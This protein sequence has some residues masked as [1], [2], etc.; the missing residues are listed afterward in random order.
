MKI[1]CIVGGTSGI[2]KAIAYQ[3]AR[4]DHSLDI[5][6]SGRNIEEGNK[7]V[8][9]LKVLS[10]KRNHQFRQIDAFLLSNIKNYCNNLKDDIKREKSSLKYLVLT[11]GI[12]SIN[13]RT[14]TPEGI[15]QKLALHYYGRMLFINELLPVLNNQEHDDDVRVVSVLSGSV[16]SPYNQMK[17]DP[18][19]KSNFSIVN[20]ANAAGFYNDLMLDSF[21]QRN[22]NISFIHAAPGFVATN[23][24]SEFPYVLKV[25]VRGLQVF[26][27]SLE[28]CGVNMA[29]ALYDDKFRPKKDAP[30][31]HVMKQDGSIGSVTSGHSTENITFISQH[32]IDMFNNKTR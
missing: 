10:P 17:E 19:L 11:Q 25:L 8:N 12:A 6:I 28:Q 24:G 9:D 3:L 4:Q 15:D 23:W 13:G 18:E 14:E 2:G 22:K 26:G 16:H 27:M 21:A 29:H 31:F 7:I 20:A 30:S 1:A 32:T 5:I